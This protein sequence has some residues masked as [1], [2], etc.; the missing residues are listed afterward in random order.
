MQYTSL[1][2]ERELPIEN[3]KMMV[4]AHTIREK[5]RAFTDMIFEVRLDGAAAAAE[6]KALAKD[7]SANCFVENTLAKA[8]PLTTEV[9]L[10]DTKIVT[11]K[12]AP[13]DTAGESNSA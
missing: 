2:M 1:V 9:F 6:V 13:E 12:R 4:R 10:N 7:A 3:I 8:I 11:L 5:P